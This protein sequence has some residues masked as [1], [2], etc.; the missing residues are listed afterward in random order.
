MTGWDLIVAFDVITACAYIGVVII[1]VQSG[2]GRAGA[3]GLPTNRSTTSTTGTWW[4]SRRS[5]GCSIR[6]GTAVTP[7]VFLPIAEAAGLMPVLG[8]RVTD[9][10]LHCLAHW[11]AQNPADVPATMSVNFSGS[12]VQDPELLEMIEKALERNGLR[13]EAFTLELAESVLLESTASTLNQLAELRACGVG[14]AI[15]AFGTGYACLRHL[16]TLAVSSVKVDRSFTST[17]ATDRTS[18][19][20]ADAIAALAAD[21]GLSCVIEGVESEQQLTALPPGVLGQGF[22]LGRPD[23]VLKSDWAIPAL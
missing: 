5:P 9:E 4:A 11:R 17:M 13:H 22:L 19:P 3:T 8:R 14:I 12:Q 23:A 7:A 15:D 6:P 16:A 20:I 1:I 21:L 18:R 2:P 10:A